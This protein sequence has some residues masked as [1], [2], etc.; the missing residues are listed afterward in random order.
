MITRI[1][2]G[3]T[4]EVKAGS[5]EAE[6]GVT[7][8]V[9]M[10][11]ALD[12]GAQ[13]TTITQGENTLRK[14]AHDI[15]S[16]EMKLVNEVMKN[17][18]TLYLWRL[19][20]GTEASIELTSNVTAKAIYPGT[21]GNRIKVTV[22]GNGNNKYTVKTYLDNVERDTQTVSSPAEFVPNAYIKLEGSGSFSG[23]SM[24]NLANG[25]DGNTPTSADYDLYLEKME[26]YDFNIMCY[27]GTDAQVKNK[28]FNWITRMRKADLAAQ[29]VMSNAAFDSPAVINSTIGGGTSAYE[30]TAAEACATMA[31]IMAKQGITSSATY[32]SVEGWTHVSPRLSTDEMIDKTKAGE[33]LFVDRKGTIQV[34][35]DVNSLTTYTDD[36][37]E[38]FH[39]NLIIRTLD[40]YGVDL[41]KM[42]DTQV[43][44]KIRAS[45]DGL[46]TIKGMICQLTTDNYLNRGYIEDFTEDD[47]SVFNY[48][49]ANMIPDQWRN[50]IKMTRDSVFIAV[51]I[52]AADMVDKIYLGVIAQ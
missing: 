10:P 11:L 50:E 42:L 24:Q 32:Y 2:P 26:S 52:K 14:L 38:D 48:E 45:Q 1:I 9:T 18:N 25:T 16:E 49:T 43:V 23:D 41:Q 13:V 20:E 40:R 3:V 39:K 21:A 31:G 22:E 19:N 8:V 47:V 15:G 35:Y 51:K 37:P 28:M 12:W 46:N 6:T 17:A 30:L 29:V 33:T 7:G 27:T 4:W 5:R 34:L 36:A 44:A